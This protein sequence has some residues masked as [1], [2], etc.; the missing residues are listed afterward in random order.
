MSDINYTPR[1]VRLL[2]ID[3][4]SVEAGSHIPDPSDEQHEA[5]VILSSYDVTNDVAD[6][7]TDETIDALEDALGIPRVTVSHCD[8]AAKL[9]K[10][11]SLFPGLTPEQVA[12]TVKIADFVVNDQTDDT[13]RQLGRR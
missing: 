4:A 12:E 13:P 10:W 9:A 2:A 7:I 8:A 6:E 5:L 3:R 11:E 1:Q